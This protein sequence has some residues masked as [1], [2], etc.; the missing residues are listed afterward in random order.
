[1]SDFCIILWT[2]K[3][4]EEAKKILKNLLDNK[5]IACATILD[6]AC[7]MY[8]WQGQIEIQKEVQVII[9]STKLNFA[10]IRVFIELNCSYEIPEILQIEIQDGLSAYLNWIKKSTI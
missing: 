2:V 5:L 10:K 8:T 1:M 6:N 9:K 7:S 3:D 4:F